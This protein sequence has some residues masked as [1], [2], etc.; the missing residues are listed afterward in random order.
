MPSRNIEDVF[1]SGGRQPLDCGLH[2][3]D[4]M[5]TTITAF[6]IVVLA[7]ILCGVAVNS[8]PTVVLNPQPTLVPADVLI[9]QPGRYRSPNGPCEIKIWS[10]SDGRLKYFFSDTT[11]NGSGPTKSFAPDS[12]WSM[13]WNTAGELWVYVAEHDPKHCHCCCVRKDGMGV[14]TAGE[15][16]GWDGIPETFKARLPVDIHE[17]CAAASVA[18]TP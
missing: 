8:R 1:P 2:P 18:K 12:N 14:R 17:M 5:K 11:G 3:I 16:G 7:G 6:L 13:C 15:A 4:A 10:E 9:S